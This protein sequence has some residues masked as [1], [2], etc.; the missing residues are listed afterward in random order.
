M[1][2]SVVSFHAQVFS[3][4]GK[5]ASTGCNLPPLLE[6]PRSHVLVSACHHCD[7]QI[8]SVSWQVGVVLLLPSAPLYSLLTMVPPKMSQSSMQR[9]K[10]PDFSIPF[11][12]YEYE[13]FL[14]LRQCPPVTGA[15]L[16]STVPLTIL[17]TVNH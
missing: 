15:L 8:A 5:L 11:C 17:S 7:M 6:H 2:L 10:E 4:F 16:V 9:S 12:V 14:T 3:P 1:H 13:P